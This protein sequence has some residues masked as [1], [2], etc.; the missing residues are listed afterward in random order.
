MAAIAWSCA[1][2]LLSNKKAGGTYNVPIRHIQNSCCMLQCVTVRCSDIQCA[3]K[4]YTKHIHA[5]ALAHVCTCT[6]TFVHAQCVAM[7]HC[8]LLHVAVRC[9]VLQCVAVCCSV[10]SPSLPFP[11]SC[12]YSHVLHTLAMGSV[13][14]SQGMTK[15]RVSVYVT[16]TIYVT[17]NDM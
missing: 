5:H 13:K 16:F 11:S 15:G 1:L 17:F 9:S 14:K 4:T 6:R 3:H 2:Y 7:C 8:V 12:Q 10:L